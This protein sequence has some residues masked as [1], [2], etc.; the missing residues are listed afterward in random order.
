MLRFHN[1]EFRVIFIQ[2][3]PPQ[4]SPNT[5]WTGRFFSSALRQY[6]FSCLNSCHSLWAWFCHQQALSSMIGRQ[7]LSH[8]TEIHCMWVRKLRHQRDGGW[9]HHLNLTLQNKKRVKLTILAFKFD[10]CFVICEH[11][12]FSGLDMKQRKK[13][14]IKFRER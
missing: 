9:F 6:A 12:S 13:W 10:C 2:T 7:S 3:V 14:E 5:K 8:A 4:M 11:T 1:I